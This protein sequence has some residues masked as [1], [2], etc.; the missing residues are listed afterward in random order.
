MLSVIWFTQLPH[1]LSFE[2]RSCLLSTCFREEVRSFKSPDY[3]DMHSRT[4]QEHPAHVL[5]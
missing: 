1:A 3:H 5:K 2:M 4:K